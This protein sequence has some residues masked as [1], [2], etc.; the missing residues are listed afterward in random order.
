MKRN[1]P[2]FYAA[3][4]MNYILGGGGFSSRLTEQVREKRGLAY[5]VYTYLNPLVHAGLISG[6][7]ATRNGKVKESIDIIRSE[8]RRLRDKGVTAK[9]L[10]D[11]KS[12]L[13][14]SFPLRLDTSEKIAQTLVAMQMDKLGIHYLDKRNAL[15]SAVT[16]KDV[17]RV[18]RRLIDPKSLLFVVVGSPKGI[19]SASAPA[20]KPAPPQGPPENPM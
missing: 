7:V 4:V 10:A 14:G 17:D 8:W 1:D 12:Y 9:E 13:T 19:S 11:A 20:P 6:G 3:Y 18:A 5:S 2:D 15:I 16:K